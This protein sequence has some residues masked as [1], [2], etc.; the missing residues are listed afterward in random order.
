[1]TASSASSSHTKNLKQINNLKSEYEIKK[2]P[3]IIGIFQ[4]LFITYFVV[5]LGLSVGTM[6]MSELTYLQLKEDFNQYY[7]SKL[8]FYELVEIRKNVRE[9]ILLQNNQT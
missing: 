1:M 5:F 3:R 8:T 4:K 9:Y 2:A 7:T 6:V